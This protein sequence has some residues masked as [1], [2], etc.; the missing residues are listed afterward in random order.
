MKNFLYKIWFLLRRLFPT[1]QEKQLVKV[2]LPIANIVEYQEKLETMTTKLQKEK[3]E[4][5][6][7]DILYFRDRVLE[8]S[9]RYFASYPNKNFF[10]FD[11]EGSNIEIIKGVTSLLIE[12]GFEAKIDPKTPC[13][14]VSLKKPGA[15]NEEQ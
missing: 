7:K 3:I 12:Q 6:K 15:K 11:I 4:R 13:R 2:N 10:L 1:K 5:N 14:Y 9:L 8:E